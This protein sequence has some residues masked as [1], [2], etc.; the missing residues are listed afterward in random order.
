M[1]VGH[2]VYKTE[3]PRAAILRQRA[4]DMAT[5]GGISQWYDIASALEQ[6]VRSHPYFIE[7]NLYANVDYYSGVVLYS[8]GMETD[9]FTPVFAMSRIA[10]WSAHIME[11]WADN[12]LIRPRGEYIGPRDLAW[13]PLEARQ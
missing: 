1:G 4:K 6:R 8:V 10:G 5:G 7:R 11:Q 3:D 2:R 9:L 13:A 12:R